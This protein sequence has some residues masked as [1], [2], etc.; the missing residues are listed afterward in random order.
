ML[1][2]IRLKEE[3]QK[4]NMTQKEFGDMLGVSATMIMYYEHGTKKPSVDQLIFISE[5]LGTDPNYLL[6]LEYEAKEKEEE[7]TFRISKQE[8]KIIKEL[9]TK[10]QVYEMLNNDPRRIVELISRKLS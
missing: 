8:I 5:K 7:Y 6:G 1:F 10:K 2:G 4:R 9:R 3:R